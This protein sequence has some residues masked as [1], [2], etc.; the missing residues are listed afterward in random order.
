MTGS[1]ASNPAL[2]RLSTYLHLRPR[3]ALGLLLGPPLLYLGVI[4][5]GSLAALVLQS[6]YHLDGFTGQVVKRIGLVV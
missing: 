6:F 1:S 4:Y 2:T 5:L 3:L